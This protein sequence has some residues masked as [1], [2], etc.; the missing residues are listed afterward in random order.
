MKI[1]TLHAPVFVPQ[2]SKLLAGR[3]D[4]KTDEPADLQAIQTAVDTLGDFKLK[5][6][7]DFRVVDSR[8][9]TTHLKRLQLI[10]VKEQVSGRPATR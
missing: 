4:G 6:A 7:A 5:T 9:N 3:P 2:W 8:Q 1:L 10:S